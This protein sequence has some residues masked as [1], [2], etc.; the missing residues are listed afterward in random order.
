MLPLG[1][2][3]ATAARVGQGAGRS[4]V[5]AVRRSAKASL[6]IGMGCITFAALLFAGLPRVWAGIYTNDPAVIA[7][8]IPIFLICGF[9]Q[10]GDAANV[11][12]CGALIGLGDTRTPLIANTAVYWTVG[13]PLSYWLAFG[14]HLDLR[15]LWLGRAAAS[16]A[17]GL[18]LALVWRAR[19]R[20]IE[21]GRR[22]DLLTLLQPMHAK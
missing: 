4:S 18:A 9:A 16:L 19:L 11:I 14:A 10:L 12:I 21:G 17:T 6:I 20:Q 8:A 15:G 13:F 22:V 3:Y 7:E 5:R 1:L 2:S